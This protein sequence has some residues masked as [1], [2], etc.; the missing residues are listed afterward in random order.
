ML[1]TFSIIGTIL[2]LWPLWLL[3]SGVLV[4]FSY[5]NRRK[6]QSIAQ[7]NRKLLLLEI[8]RANEKKELAAEQMFASLHGILKS[9]GELLKSGQRVNYKSTYP[10]R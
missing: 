4:F 10:L 8:P 3:V 9:K 1:E 7:E 5:Q 6:S 2:G